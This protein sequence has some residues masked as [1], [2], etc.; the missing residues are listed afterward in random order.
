MST[1]NTTTEATRPTDLNNTTDVGK[2]YFETDSSKI[3][4]WD[5]SLW[6]EWNKDLIVSPGF[7]NN[8]SGSFNGSSDYLD[9]GSISTL[10]GASAQSLS[11]WFKPTS[12]GKVVDVGYRPSATSLFGFTMAGSVAYF[13]VR[14]GATNLYTITSAIPADTLW[15]HY[16]GVFNAGTVTVYIDGS[17][18]SGTV[19]GTT[20]STI[21]S[22]AGDFYI[23]RFG[24]SNNYAAGLIDEVALWDVALDSDDASALYNSG[25]P[26]ALSSAVAGYDKQADLTHWWR[27]GDHASD[28]GSGGSPASGDT[29]S[30][31]ENA[32]NPNTN[33]A[34]V[35][36]GSPTYST[37]VP[38]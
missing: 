1:L 3:L 8:F 25:T 13:N 9:C 16:L 37:T 11:I 22:T 35:G 21:G 7:D 15:H 17:E 18:V 31:V 29:I 34:S 23:G 33:D 38:V 28:T 24:D 30:N 12:S 5:G 27:I 26:I 4:V 32:A 2:S 19:S 6:N 20:P 36:G 14:N 10:L